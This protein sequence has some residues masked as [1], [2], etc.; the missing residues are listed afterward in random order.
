MSDINEFHTGMLAL[1][2]SGMAPQESRRTKSEQQ[3]KK[4]IE[5]RRKK[6][7]PPCLL[8]TKRRWDVAVEK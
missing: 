7:L 4:L 1:A 2:P 6:Q 8:W 3:K 5:K